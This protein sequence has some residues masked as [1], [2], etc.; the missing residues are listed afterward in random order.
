MIN[1]RIERRAFLQKGLCLAALS[2]MAGHGFADPV[3]TH[4]ASSATLGE[5][6]GPVKKVLF[7][8]DTPVASLMDRV[9]KKLKGK[10]ELIVPASNCGNTVDV[11][12]D[13]ASWLKIH[14]PDVVYI[15]TGYED[16]RTIYYGSYQSMVP[17]NFYKLNLRGIFEFIYEFSDK[18]IPIWSTIPPVDDEKLTVDKASVRDYTFFND[19]IIAYN[20][21]AY[22]VCR[23]M[24]VM[25]ADVNQ[26][27]DQSGT[28]A[29]LDKNGYSLNNNGRAA[30]SNFI[31]QKIEGVL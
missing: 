14:D 16:V 5:D 4:S 18:A 24:N 25:V 8:G 26:F 17:R 22:K 15:S 7:I 31:A 2:A 19:D 1:K 23:K 28:D 12:K 10:A 13:L 20:K 27:I 21:E 29:M 6:I 3:P 11:M 9:S 30:L